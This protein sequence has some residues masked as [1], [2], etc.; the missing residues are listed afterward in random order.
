MSMSNITDTIRDHLADLADFLRPVRSYFYWEKHC[1]D[2]P[3]CWAIRSIF[4]TFDGVD[5]L[6]EKLGDLVQEMDVLIRL[7]AAVAQML[8]MISTR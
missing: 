1:Y 6:S 3:V 4:D 8:P 7:A 2:I 5:Q